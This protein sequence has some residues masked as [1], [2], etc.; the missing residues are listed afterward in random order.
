MNKF[1]RTMSVLALASL[2]TF[3]MA[4]YAFAE[5][6]YYSNEDGSNTY[7]D[8]CEAANFTVTIDGTEY[9]PGDVASGFSLDSN[10]S[11]SAGA[12]VTVGWEP[13]S[14]VQGSYGHGAAHTTL[15]DPGYLNVPLD[16]TW[17]NLNILPAL[18]GNPMPLLP[19]FP[20]I[21]YAECPGE[22]G[23][24]YIQTFPGLTLD[25]AGFAANLEDGVYVSDQAQL[26]SLGLNPTLQVDSSLLYAPMS[27]FRNAAYAFWANYFESMFFDHPSAIWSLEPLVLDGD[28]VQAVWGWVGWSFDPQTY[29]EFASSFYSYSN[30]SE[31]IESRIDDVFA[32]EVAPPS[33]LAT[34]GAHVDWLV[35]GSLTA[36]AA[37]AGFFALGR[38]KRTA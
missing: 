24:A 8:N 33:A 31:I 21:F 38:R 10:Y 36:V 20:S 2:T 29:S 7:V 1:T 4:L 22:E 12:G 26:D 34:T 11:I 14:I 15:G 27:N 37:G 32:Q 16:G 25:Q 13:I 17:F 18:N 30:G 28:S 6:P 23:F 19:F 3:G 35:F 9:G 5:E